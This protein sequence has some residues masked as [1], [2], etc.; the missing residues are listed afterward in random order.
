[1]K[2]HGE[3]VAYISHLLFHYKREFYA[4]LE[5]LIP[6]RGILYSLLEYTHIGASF[7]TDTTHEKNIH[8]LHFFL[9]TTIM[10][11]LYC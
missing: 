10:Y 3:Y 8:Y 11:L 9:A 5:L 2:R 4:I 6:A 7:H 1:M